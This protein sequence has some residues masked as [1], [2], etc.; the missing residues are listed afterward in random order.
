MGKLVREVLVGQGITVRNV[1][2][3]GDTSAVA[4]FD[5][6]GTNLGLDSGILISTGKAV[7]AIGPNNTQVSSSNNKAGDADLNIIADGFTVDAASIQFDFTPVTSSIKLRFVFASEEYPEFVGQ[8]YNDV[9]GFFVSGPGIVGKKN[10]AIIPGSLNMPIAIST[11]NAVTNSNL[12]V[13]NTNGTGVQYDAFTSVIELVLAD[14][15]PCETYTI[16]LAIADVIDRAYDSGIF[17]EAQS[18]ESEKVDNINVEIMHPT[19]ATVNEKCDSVVVRF[20]RTSSDL[21]AALFGSYVTTGAATRGVDY[22]ILNNAINIPAG[23]AFSEFFFYPMDD[24]IVEIPEKFKIEVTSNGSCYISADSINIK[25]FDTLKITGFQKLKCKG[26]TLYYTVKTSG[27]SAHVAYSWTDSLAIDT[28]SFIK[29]LMVSPDSL[30]MYVVTAFDSCTNTL[31]KDTL[32]L[33][34]IIPTVLHTTADTVVCAGTIFNLYAS[35]TPSIP[36]PRYA[37]TATDLSLQTAGII[38]SLSSKPLVK[39]TVPN[40]VYEIN[41]TVS[42]LNEEACAEPVTFKVRIIPKGIYGKKP[43]YICLNDTA[44]LLAYGGIHYKWTPSTGLS[45]DTIYN[46]KAWLT[47]TYSVEIEDSI[48]CKV[49]Y[50]IN[51][52][53]DTLPIAYAGTDKIICKRSEV[54]LN[55]SGSDY[56]TYEWSP[57]QSLDNYKSKTPKATPIATTTYYLKA[58][59][60]ACFT[61]DTVLVSVVDSPT[62]DFTMG[63]DSCLRIV[64]F[65]NNSIGTDSMFWDFGDGTTSLERS[66][67]H[68]YQTTGNYTIKLIANRNTECLDSMSSSIVLNDVDINQRVVPNVITPNGD[69]YNDKFV[70]TGGNVECAI[71]KI[72]IYN[73]WGRLLFKTENKNELQWDGKVNGVVLPEGTYFY[74]IE[75][76]G[77]KDTGTI[78]LVL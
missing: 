16:K 58:F 5:G 28:I 8:I 18:F 60:N 44:Q 74:L 3:R 35:I 63:I 9:F 13:D 26:D 57:R 20:T 76:K 40:G 24:N 54:T 37:W 51:V 46:P 14:L 27:G 31:V 62:V 68:E 43:A 75:G 25:D 15:I 61:Y 59:N 19:G 67:I 10:I 47:N 70:V 78:S 6:T 49:T 38:D 29:I 7:D 53:V 4:V 22:P 55:A 32:Y 21:T 39:Y 64:A 72:Y 30:T 45:N 56:D 33:A 12:Y 2:F 41:V 66:P 17:L 36:N 73:R 48:H 34:P 65:K 50:S 11:I 42:L 52:K 69:G 23:A 77:F 71:E 1:I